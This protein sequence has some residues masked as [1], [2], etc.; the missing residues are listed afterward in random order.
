MATLGLYNDARFPG[1]SVLGLNAHYDA[2]EDLPDQLYQEFSMAGLISV[3]AIADVT[4]KVY[5]FV[6]TPKRSV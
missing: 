6:K 4:G 2:L 1:R 5:P 3:R